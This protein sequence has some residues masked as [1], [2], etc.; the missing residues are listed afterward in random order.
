MVGIVCAMS[1]KIYV[2]AYHYLRNCAKNH[3]H[4]K[5]ILHHM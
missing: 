1:Y 5:G 4:K 2:E 3:L